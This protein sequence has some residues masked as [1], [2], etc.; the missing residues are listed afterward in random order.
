MFECIHPLEKQEELWFVYIFTTT[1]CWQIT[2]FFTHFRSIKWY[3][4]E[5]FLAVQW[6]RLCFPMQGVWVQSLVRE[7]RSI[8][9]MNKTEQKQYCDK[10]STDFKKNDPHQ[11]NYLKNSVSWLFQ[12]AFPDQQFG[13]A[14]HLRI[15]DLLSLLSVN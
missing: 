15:I 3:F 7:L 12:F 8:C 4:M 13:L 14:E 5:T 1:Y 10:F 9:L 11:K 6:L 2:Q